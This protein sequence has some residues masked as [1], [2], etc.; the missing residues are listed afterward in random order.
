MCTWAQ[1]TPQQIIVL[2]ITMSA[3]DLASKSYDYV[4]CGGGTAGLVIAARLT[5]DPNVTV[6]ILEAGGNGLNDMLI[7]APNLFL[8]L[9]GK[10]QY[11]WDYKTVPQVRSAILCMRYLFNKALGRDRRPDSWLGERK[12]LRR[13]LR[14]QLYVHFRTQLLKPYIALTK[15]LLVNMFSMASRQDLDNWSELG[16]KGWGF[17]NLLP[18]YRKFETYHPTGNAFAEKVNDKYLDATLRGTSGPVHV[19]H[20]APFPSLV[21]TKLGL[22]AWRR[23]QLDPRRVAKNDSQRRIQAI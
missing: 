21:L 12:S 16:N 2:I 7:D 14:S 22:S 11:D 5:E 20:P 15:R 4:I 10:P 3:K 1:P 8:Q 19:N 17:D 6:G 9:Q 23:A 18:Y 13:Q